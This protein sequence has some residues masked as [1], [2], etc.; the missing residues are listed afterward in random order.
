MKEVPVENDH[1]PYCLMFS[2]YLSTALLI[3]I[4][5]MVIDLFLTLPILDL[6]PA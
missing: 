5:N 2:V 6:A 3:Y 1:D 4:Y